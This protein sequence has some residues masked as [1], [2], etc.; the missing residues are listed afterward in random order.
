MAFF[1]EDPRLMLAAWAA[2]F[3][4]WSNSCCAL[5]AALAHFLATLRVRLSAFL[6]ALYL[7]LDNLNALSAAAALRVAAVA[8]A[9]A[10]ARL[11]AGGF[12]GICRK[13]RWGRKREAISQL[14]QFSI[15]RSPRIA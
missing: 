3:W 9:V 11:V 8:W 7:D 1:A 6:A 13:I 2:S 4:T 15:L 5:R 10:S 12:I 14:L